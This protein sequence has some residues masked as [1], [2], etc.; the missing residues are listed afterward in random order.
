MKRYGSILA[1]DKVDFSLRRGEVH[2]LLGENGAGKS[3]LSK[4]LYGFTH[5]D[6][7][8]DP[9]DG[10]RAEF[11]SPRDARGAGDRHGLSELHAHPC[12]ERA[13]ERRAFPFRPSRRGPAGGRRQRA[14]AP[15]PSA[16]VSPSTPPR[17]SGSSPWE[18]SR[19]WRS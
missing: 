4:V 3:T 18:T 1:N 9:V 19:R 12:A 10:K 2:A 15:L 6:E 14:S 17:P 7:R 11:R 8:R 5:P 13:G 16:S